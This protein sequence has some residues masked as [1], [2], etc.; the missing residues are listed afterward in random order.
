[1]TLLSS[2]PS[3]V[4]SSTTRSTTSA[5]VVSAAG[6]LV[7]TGIAILCSRNKEFFN[8]TTSRGEKAKGKERDDSTLTG[9]HSSRHSKAMSDSEADVTEMDKPP[10]AYAWEPATS[11]LSNNLVGLPLQTANSS[12]GNK[13]LERTIQTRHVLV[14]EDDE[15][16]H[17]LASMSF[18]NGGIRAPS[19]PCCL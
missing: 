3:N 16:L 14:N 12:S 6:F 7:V 4:S 13:S 9:R 5:E 17:F 18:A 10:P 11:P 1:M 19:C 15:S 2:S 8:F